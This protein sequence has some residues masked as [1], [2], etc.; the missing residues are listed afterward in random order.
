MTIGQ[1]A[2]GLMVIGLVTWKMAVQKLSPG[3]WV[4]R[5]GIMGCDW[6]TAS[7][8][9]GSEQVRNNQRTA[10]RATGTVLTTG[11]VAVHGLATHG[12]ASGPATI[13]HGMRCYPGCF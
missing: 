13:C 6:K 7:F 8:L 1:V 12:L 10:R 5:T 3:C 9:I 4:A 2:Q 11:Q